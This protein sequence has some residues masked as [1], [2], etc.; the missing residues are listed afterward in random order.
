VGKTVASGRLSGVEKR[1]APSRELVLHVLVSLGLCIL[2]IGC[3]GG[4]GS[5]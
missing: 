5:C 3:G 1:E 4:L 2:L